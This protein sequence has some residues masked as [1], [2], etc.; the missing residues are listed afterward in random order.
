M[1]QAEIQEIETQRRIQ[2]MEL[3]E[4]WDSA[5]NLLDSQQYDA[6]IKAFEALLSG[7]IL[8]SLLPYSGCDS[9]FILSWGSENYFC[10]IAEYL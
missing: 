8:F 4:Q 3:T 6:S 2:E 9:I 10:Y 5:L 7:N 1:G